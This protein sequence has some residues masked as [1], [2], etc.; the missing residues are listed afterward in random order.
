MERFK[1]LKLLIKS[2]YHENLKDDKIDGRK[3]KKKKRKDERIKLNF[4]RKVY[5][6][7]SIFLFML[8]YNGKEKG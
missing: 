7:V 1:T 4:G 6:L 2:I 5:R 3:I 8:E